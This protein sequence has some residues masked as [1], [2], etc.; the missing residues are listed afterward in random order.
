MMQFPESPLKNDQPHRSA[1]ILQ[2]AALTEKRQKMISDRE[3][4]SSLDD[5]SLRFTCI[6]TRPER[7]RTTVWRK[8]A[9]GNA[10]DRQNDS[11]S[12]A[13]LEP[14][15]NGTAPGR[16]QRRGLPMREIRGRFGDCA[17][18]RAGT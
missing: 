17:G 4:R 7:R 16:N 18:R 15:T 5:T 3:A 13:A 14:A 10:P 9:G 1:L 2:R 11:D 12:L 6:S 8:H